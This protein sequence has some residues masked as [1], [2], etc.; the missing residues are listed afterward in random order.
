MLDVPS[1]EAKTWTNPTEGCIE[2]GKLLGWWYGSRHVMED[3]SRDYL[4]WTRRTKSHAEEISAKEVH[5]LP[6]GVDTKRFASGNKEDF[7]QKYT[8][9]RDQKILLTLGRID[10]QKNQLFII[11]LLP[12]L[13]KE[14]SNLHYVI[15]GHVTNDDYYSTI[16]KTIESSGLQNHCTVI[17]G[18]DP[19]GD[20]LVN[21]Y[22]AA[23]LFLLPSIH[24]PFG[25]V[26]LEALSS[27]CPVIASHV[28]GIPYV[29]SNG[30]DGVLLPT[31]DEKAWIQ[32]I[33]FHLKN[34][35]SNLDMIENGFKNVLKN[36]DWSVITDRLIKI[37]DKVISRA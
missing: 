1:E 25:I 11:Q 27:K 36:Y 33:I 17:P 4:R 5:Y 37:Y 21:A 6:N 8:I 26:L 10:P 28:G 2:W 19:F 24:E 20:D 18:I 12:E 16:Q 29:I 14:I 35:E 32:K 13:L 34:K 7:L 30:E 3:A 22:H 15:I 23:D 31:N 9:S